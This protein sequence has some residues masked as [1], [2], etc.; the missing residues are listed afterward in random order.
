MQRSAVMYLLNADWCS[1]IVCLQESRIMVESAAVYDA[2]GKPG[3]AA[4]RSPPQTLPNT[5]VS[6]R[7]LQQVVPYDAVVDTRGD[8]LAGKRKQRSADSCSI[9]PR[10]YAL[11]SELH[12][13][14]GRTVHQLAA[15]CVVQAVTEQTGD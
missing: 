2:L 11:R 6:R 9:S 10:S 1:S 14:L 3:A 12:A 5:P 4:F 13:S 8:V 15:L 7:A